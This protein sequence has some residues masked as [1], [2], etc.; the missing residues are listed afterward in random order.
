MTPLERP[1][2]KEYWFPAKR[3]GWGWGFP[4]TWQGWLVLMGYFGLVF[5]GIPL[6]HASRGSDAFAGYVAL[7]T[8]GLIV[9]CWR[10]G[11][12][13]RWRWGGRDE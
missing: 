7:L 12:P 11:E 1:P 4:S 10:K 3:Y 2:R 5:A 9:I 8:V 13:P 6:V